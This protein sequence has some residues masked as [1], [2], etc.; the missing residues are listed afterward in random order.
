MKSIEQRRCVQAS[1]AV[2]GIGLDGRAQLVQV[3]VDAGRIQQQSIARRRDGIFTESGA[4]H[5]DGEI[6]Q[7]ARAGDVLLRPQHRHRP[8]AR[9]R[10]GP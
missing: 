3:A 8:I 5:V 9:Q 7:T 4:Q 1:H 6:E 10:L 2:G